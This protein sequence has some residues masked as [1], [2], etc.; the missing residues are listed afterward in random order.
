MSVASR[1]LGWVRVRV[2]TLSVA[3]RGRP[4]PGAVVS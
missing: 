1:G 2:L 3:S 4:E